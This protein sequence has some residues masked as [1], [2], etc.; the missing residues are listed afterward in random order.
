[1]SFSGCFQPGSISFLPHGDWGTPHLDAFTTFLN[2]RLLLFYLHFHLVIALDVVIEDWTN[3]YRYAYSQSV[4]YQSDFNP[5]FHFMC[6]NFYKLMQHLLLNWAKNISNTEIMWSAVWVSLPASDQELALNEKR[7]E[8]NELRQEETSLQKQITDG[9]NRLDSLSQTVKMTQS[10]IYQT[11]STAI[12]FDWQFRLRKIEDLRQQQLKMNEVI[13]EFH[14]EGSFTV[15]NNDFVQ[16][17]PVNITE[18]DGLQL[19]AEDDPF[20]KLETSFHADDPFKAF[21]D[22]SRKEDISKVEDSKEQAAISFQKSQDSSSKVEDIFQQEDFFSEFTEP[23]KKSE[24]SFD[25]GF[26]GFSSDPFGSEDPFKEDPFK[27]CGIIETT[28]SD[29]FGEDPFQE[30]LIG[31]KES[32]KGDPFESFPNDAGTTDVT[33]L[34]DPF[35]L[36]NTSS[37][38][39]VEDKQFHEEYDPF[40]TDPFSAFSGP[41]SPIPALPPRKSKAPPPQP[42][43]P[44]HGV[45]A[46]VTSTAQENVQNEF[47]DNLFALASQSKDFKG[48]VSDPFDSLLSVEEK[49]SV[50]TINSAVDPF[51]PFGIGCDPFSNSTDAQEEFANFADFDKVVGVAVKQKF[52]ETPPTTSPSQP[53]NPN[54]DNLT[55]EEQLAWVTQ[56]S[57]RLEEARAESRS[58]GAGRSRTCPSFE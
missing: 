5:T 4:P 44:K 31:K 21:N 15:K 34:F 43:P 56:E 23:V 54:L 29:P 36:S 14:T 8:L 13:A 28:P 3:C 53:S 20:G 49:P 32:N 6:A 25:S 18:A 7:H 42:V 10:E 33:D 19:M 47:E 2:I 30:E 35:G 46:A 55:E 26:N 37:S 12:T 45:N 22:S 58:P 41:E 17:A 11:L 51:D 16:V 40:G 24:D 1:M 48:G 9:Q 39:T 52:V 38:V 50:G 27:D 57:L